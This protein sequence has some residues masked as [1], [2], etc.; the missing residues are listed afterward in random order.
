MR[1]CIVMAALSVGLLLSGYKSAGKSDGLVTS[2]TN[3]SDS[4]KDAQEDVHEDGELTKRELRVIGN[5]LNDMQYYGFL[6]SDYDDPRYIDWNEVFYNGADLD[7]VRRTKGIEQAYL[8]K[9]KNGEIIGDLTILSGEDVEDFVRNTTG[10][11]Y[12]KMRNPLDW[13]YLKKDD[14]YVFE[15]GDT[16]WCTSE[17]LSGYVEDGVFTVRYLHDNW[18][19]DNADCEYEVCFTENGDYYC[20]ISNTPDLST[21]SAGEYIFPESDSRNLKKEDLEGLDAETLRIGRNEIYARHGR[22]FKD[23]KLQEYFESKSWYKPT[24][25]SDAAIEKAFNQYEKDN[26]KLIQSYESKAPAG[27][28]KPQSSQTSQSSGSKP[29]NSGSGSQKPGSGYTDAQLCKMAQ[30]YYE[31]H[32]HYRP[33]IAEIDSTDGDNVTIHLYEDMGDHTATSAWYVI[34][35]KTGK[36]HDDIFGDEI[37]LTK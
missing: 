29:G 33:P 3:T 14:L 36:G 17:V 26:V 21:K 16:N 24:N 30:D 4:R 35:R 12:S 25:D 20:F 34:N 23:S 8:D 28:S 11:S 32:N 37:D 10:L 27:G 31:K 7:T 1:Y 18:W 22:K 13:V 2:R 19:G 15:H 9:T 6:L 5:A